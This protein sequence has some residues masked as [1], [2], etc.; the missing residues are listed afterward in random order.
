M[1][2]PATPMLFAF[3][4]RY[5]LGWYEDHPKLVQQ[6]RPSSGPNATTFSLTLLDINA[7][8]VPTSPPKN[9]VFGA[10]FLRSPAYQPVAANY[11][12][13]YQGKYTVAGYEGKASV[14][15][16]FVEVKNKIFDEGFF[17]VDETNSVKLVWRTEDDECQ[18]PKRTPG[19]TYPCETLKWRDPVIGDWSVEILGPIDGPSVPISVTYTPDCSVPDCASSGGGSQSGGGGPDRS[20]YPPTCDYLSGATY[21]RDGYC[22]DDLNVEECN[23]DGGDCCEDTCV[24]GMSYECGANLYDCKDPWSKLISGGE[25][26]RGGL[27]GVL[28][29]AGAVA[30]FLM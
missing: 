16:H 2:N 29:A 1:G 25:G 21:F 14:S 20:V 15:V 7:E 8:D 28:A 22:D 19:T 13:A 10:Y 5:L 6:L 27:L 11:V 30:V 18:F 4:H 12:I 24:D 17:E 9:S 3:P 23:Y 26:G